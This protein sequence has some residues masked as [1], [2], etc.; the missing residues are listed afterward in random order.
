MR[1]KLA[2][3]FKSVLKDT[4][5]V[6]SLTPFTENCRKE[7]PMNLLRTA[8]RL[9]QGWRNYFRGGG[10][11]LQGPKVIPSKTRKGHWI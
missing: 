10:L 1:I 8:H 2:L 7:P 11:G 5:L 3:S 9:Q 4:F 6:S